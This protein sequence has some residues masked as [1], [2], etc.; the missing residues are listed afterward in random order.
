MDLL[1]S[2]YTL[3]FVHKKIIYRKQRAGKRYF[4]PP[5]LT[6]EGI[7]FVQ[8]T[9]CSSFIA[10]PKYLLDSHLEIFPSS[11]LTPAPSPGKMLSP[12]FSLPWAEADM[13]Y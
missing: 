1:L 11:L 10:Y 5:A 9:I 8:T 12:Y 3:I 4:L 7:S 6:W 2:R 13:P